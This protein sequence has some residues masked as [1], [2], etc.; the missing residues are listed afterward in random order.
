M[1]KITL[2]HCVI[3]L[4]IDKLAMTSV[5][6]SCHAVHNLWFAMWCERLHQRQKNTDRL[7]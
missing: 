7:L 5:D 2:L 4:I 1:L 6:N 3:V